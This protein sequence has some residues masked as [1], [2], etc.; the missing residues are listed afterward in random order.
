MLPEVGQSVVLSD[1]DGGEHRSETRGVS[2]EQLTVL[3][4]EQLAVGVPL[5]IGADLTLS[6]ASGDGAVNKVRARIAK[7]RH[8][9]ETRLWDLEPTG[10]PWREQRRSWVRVPASG[11]I[12]VTELVDEIRSLAPRTA[13]GELL[14]ISEVANRCLI[15]ASAIWAARRN[16]RVRATFAL[17]SHEVQLD[18]RVTASKF[19]AD[20]AD[21]REV[22][23]Q[24]DQPVPAAD[25][26]RRH[27]QSQQ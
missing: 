9:G 6:W 1:E 26:L 3:R 20:G 12:T 15:D 4:P 25:T 10:E 21:R 5:L 16:A 19:S 8:D 17:G 24:F 22:V 18:G 11:P 7:M 27:V 14:D 23:I 2:A 13:T